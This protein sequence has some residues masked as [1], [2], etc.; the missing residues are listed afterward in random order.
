MGISVQ[1]QAAEQ[2]AQAEQLQQAA[3]D[4]IRVVLVETSH[5]GNIG[6]AARAVKNMGLSQLVLVKP[7]EFP[8]AEATAL[9]SSA[10][11]I[12]HNARVVD[13]LHEAIQ[14]CALVCG[15]SARSRTLSWP[16]LEARECGAKLVGEAVSAPVAIV[17][18]RERTGLS[19][20][21]L[22]QCHYHVS[23]PANPEYSSLNLAQAVQLLT[24]EIRMSALAGKVPQADSGQ[25]PSADNMSRFYTHLEQT[26]SQTGFIN[27]AHP[28]Q[29]MAKLRRLFT[30]AR[31][32]QEELNILRGMLTSVNKS[33]NK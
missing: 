9:A 14:D 21:E 4:N 17:F 25:Y 10:G 30:R 20:D 26:F 12:L 1:Q 31:P 2:V 7:R 27:Q 29:I 32:E 24:Y 23:I 16:H 22:Q 15:T 3:R 19:N 5:S 8:S 18:G 28:G 33:I 6:S 11:D 13:T